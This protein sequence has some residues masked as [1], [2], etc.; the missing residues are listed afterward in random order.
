M[1][2][3]V[4]IPGKSTLFQRKNGEGVDPEERRGGVA[5]GSKEK[6]GGLF[7]YFEEKLI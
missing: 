5:R 1:Q 2:H 4:A 7:M 6:T 3:S